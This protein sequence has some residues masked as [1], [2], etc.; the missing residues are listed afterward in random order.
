MAL[1]AP[2]LSRSHS[3]PFPGDALDEVLQ[4]RVDV[5]IHPPPPLQ[6]V[7]EPG[8]EDARNDEKEEDA[9]DRVCP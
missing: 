8:S 7:Q 9:D 4:G 1:P 6:G 5:H 3:L 2:P